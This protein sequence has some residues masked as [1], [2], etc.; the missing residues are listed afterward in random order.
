MFDVSFYVW[1]FRT[2]VNEIISILIVWA[3]TCLPKGHRLTSTKTLAHY[4]PDRAPV[5]VPELPIT[6]CAG[7]TNNRLP[8]W[9]KLSAIGVTE[10]IVTSLYSFQ[11]RRLYFFA[12]HIFS[13]IPNR[14]LSLFFFGKRLGLDGLEFE[15]KNVQREKIVCHSCSCSMHPRSH[16]G[17][18][19]TPVFKSL[20]CNTRDIGTREPSQRYL[21]Y[22]AF[23][24]CIMNIY[25][26]IYTPCVHVCVCICVRVCVCV[27]GVFA[28]QKVFQKLERFNER[29]GL[30]M[31]INELQV[32]VRVNVYVRVCM[33]VR[34]YACVFVW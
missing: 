12:L 29:R 34:V 32:C 15:R 17:N 28:C 25:A 7:S 2:C 30:I 33:C 6:D 24:F 27:R 5:R 26:F 16:F 9:P 22:M 21:W 19:T 13:E 10:N 23:Q 8:R 11:D 31:R 1:S 18:H 3:L 14:Q 4:L 20:W